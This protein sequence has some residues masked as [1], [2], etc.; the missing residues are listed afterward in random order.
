[1]N[2]LSSL[3]HSTVAIIIILKRAHSLATPRPTN[4]STIIADFCSSLLVAVCALLLPPLVPLHPF[5][6]SQVEKEE[7]EQYEEE[8]W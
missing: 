2:T 8:N 7:E 5:L 4:S 1:M 6:C 3:S